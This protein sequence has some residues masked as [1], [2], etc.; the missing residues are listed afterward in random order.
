MY[1][2]S[3]HE[4]KNNGYELWCCH[5]VFWKWTWKKVAKHEWSSGEKTLLKKVESPN[6]PVICLKT[7]LLWLAMSNKVIREDMG[8]K[9][10]KT[11]LIGHVADF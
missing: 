1:F 6:F 7:I 9:I 8:E 10:L 4:E 2:G 5:F 3:E 11:I